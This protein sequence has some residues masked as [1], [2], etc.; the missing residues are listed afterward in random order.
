M[1]IDAELHTALVP[2]SAASALADGNLTSRRTLSYEY[3]CS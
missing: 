1:H 3:E 2:F